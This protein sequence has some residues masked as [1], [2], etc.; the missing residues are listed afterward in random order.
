MLCNCK[1]AVTSV[2]PVFTKLYKLKT[3]KR[4]SIA[5]HKCGLCRGYIPLP[6][7]VFAR[8]LEEGKIESVASFSLELG[9]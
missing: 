2:R 5:I 1:Q 9:I 3:E 6:E 7:R 4:L 8:F